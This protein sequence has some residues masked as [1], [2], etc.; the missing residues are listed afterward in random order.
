MI[1][2]SHIKDHA[3][4]QALLQLQQQ[5]STAL[6]WRTDGTLRVQQAL[7]SMYGSIAG[8]PWF[9]AI[10]LGGSQPYSFAKA[11]P[12]ALGVWY[13]QS[14]APLYGQCANQRVTMLANATWNGSSVSFSV[15]DDVSMSVSVGMSFTVQGANPATFNGDY[16]VTS[17]MQMVG[18]GT[19]ITAILATSPGTYVTDGAVCFYGTTDYAARPAY[20]ENDNI[21]VQVG[22]VVRMMPRIF[23]DNSVYTTQGDEEYRFQHCCSGQVPPAP[24]QFV[25]QFDEYSVN[26]P[27][28]I[29]P[30]PCC[31]PM[32][33]NMNTCNCN[34]VEYTQSAMIAGNTNN[35]NLATSM[36]NVY[37]QANTSGPYQLTGL[38]GGAIGQDVLVQN[39]GSGLLTIPMGS[40]SST[41]PFNNSSGTYV[42]LA[43]RQT[44]SFKFDGNTYWQTGQSNL[45]TLISNINT[46]LVGLG[47]QYYTTV[48]NG[49]TSLSGVSTGFSGQVLTSNGNSAYP[50]YQNVNTGLVGGAQYDTA[51]WSGASALTTVNPVAGGYILTSNGNTA[52][53]SYQ[54]LNLN[55]SP[56]LVGV[57]QSQYVPAVN[58]ATT[59]PGGVTGVLLITNGGTG[60]SSGN[61][62]GSGG[63]QNPYSGSL[64]ATTTAVI[65]DTTV[66]NGILGGGTIQNTGGNSSQTKVTATNLFSNA[67]VQGPNTFAASAIECWMMD[68]SFIGG[69]GVDTSTTGPPYKEEKLEAGHF[70]AGLASTYQAYEVHV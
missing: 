10:I 25:P 26:E 48:W 39:T 46:G 5:V 67:Q 9:M 7:G 27:D 51:V 68:M 17:I 35:L 14:T 18:Q 20:E 4:R 8:P 49:N 23:E 43:Q 11:H 13:A 32:S 69:T 63:Q 58:L 36:Q 38:L 31:A 29:W 3:V 52:Y 70:N 34:T 66:S 65:F 41:Y 1:D 19:T 24:N 42:M 57:L 40:A 62:S 37:L 44:A 30:Q 2:V 45:N 59:G 60:N 56:A 64:S 47:S 55:T 12:D 33:S 28:F 54:Q 16:V 21:S 50:S 22:T 15:T 6:N 53:P 61:T